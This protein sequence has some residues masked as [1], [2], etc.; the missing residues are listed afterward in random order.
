[1]L[2]NACGNLVR[3]RMPR[4]GVDLIYHKS[5][6]F[7]LL[8]TAYVCAPLLEVV[9]LVLA[10]T[11]ARCALRAGIQCQLLHIKVIGRASLC[12]GVSARV[13]ARTPFIYALAARNIYGSLLD[14]ALAAFH[15][16]IP[17]LAC[18]AHHFEIHALA[19]PLSRRAAGRLRSSPSS[20]ACARKSNV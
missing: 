4:I 9:T 2:V 14:D 6:K 18:A 16:E 3:V 8:E 12:A 15:I 19:Y 17:N 1:M 10:V 5:R 13:S 7:M 11:S 20:R